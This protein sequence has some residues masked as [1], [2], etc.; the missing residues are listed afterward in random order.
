MSK[1]NEFMHQREILKEL[2]R[3]CASGK[4]SLVVDFDKLLEFDIDLAKQLVFYNASSFLSGAD[5][6]LEQ[7][8]KFPGM[9]LRV[10]GLDKT[11][12]ADE[13][14]AEHV[15][16]FVQ[17]EGTVTEVGRPRLRKLNVDWEEY[18]DYQEAQLDGLGVVLARDLVG[19][20]GAGDR[21]VIT[22]II[23]AV[24][25]GGLHDPR[26]IVNHVTNGGH[27]AGQ[28]AGG[29]SGREIAEVPDVRPARDNDKKKGGVR[30]GAG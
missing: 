6:E 30:N 22:G 23:E 9:R 10:Q 8:T 27:G 21:V 12:K 14:R 25:A 28:D 5:H 3:V 4:T 7:I 11:M 16:K 20:V 15:G 17:I 26:L 19:T 29:A 13:I 2:R 1:I 18:E 24:P